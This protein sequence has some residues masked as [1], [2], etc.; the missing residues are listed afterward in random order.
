MLTIRSGKSFGFLPTRLAA[1]GTKERAQWPF[2]ARIFFLRTIL[3]R[4]VNTVLNERKYLKM[5]IRSVPDADG[6]T[7]SPLYTVLNSRL[8]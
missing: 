4:E 2:L 8:V 6:L 3:F 1:L 7:A 5:V